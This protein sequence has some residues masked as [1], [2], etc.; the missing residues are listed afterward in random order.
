LTTG[1]VIEFEMNRPGKMK[2]AVLKA[3]RTKPPV[4]K[5]ARNQAGEPGLPFGLKNAYLTAG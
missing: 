3:G 1:L 5:T 2:W 4:C